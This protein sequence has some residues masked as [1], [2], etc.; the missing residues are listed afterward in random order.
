MSLTTMI[1]LNNG[2]EIPMLGFGT[3]QAKDGEEAYNAIKTAI[4][5]GYRHIDTAAVYGNEE[6]VGKAVKDSGISRDEIFITS[7]LWNADRGYDETIAAF[8]ETIK[9]LDTDYL[10]LYLI[11]WPNPAAFRDEWKKKNAESWKA[12]EDLYESGKIRA[13][14]ISNFKPRHMEALAETW[15]ITPMVNQVRI[16]PG[17]VPEDVVEYC[18]KH[19][20]LIE[21]YSPLGSGKV[22]E[23]ESMKSLADKYGKS[24]AQLCIRFSIQ[25]G[26]L[27][28]PKSVTKERI[29][30]NADVFD[31]EISK[32]DMDIIE[33]TQ[34]CAQNR[35]PDETTF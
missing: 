1:K 10:D 14:G 18:L 4:E 3:W 22:F 21:A 35:N 9:K 8:N 25:K 19:N 17:E 32:E 16:C 11:H 24:I 7:K 2:V 5:A 33:T 15:K 34:G 12:M 20:I 23:L 31:F 13:I 28:L 26:F 29:I 27:P 30:A 6:S